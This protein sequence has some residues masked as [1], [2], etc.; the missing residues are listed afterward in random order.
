M[1]NDNDGKRNPCGAYLPLVSPVL[2]DPTNSKCNGGDSQKGF[3]NGGKGQGFCCD[4]MSRID[5]TS[6]WIYSRSYVP[7]VAAFAV[8]GNC[9]GCP[10]QVYEEISY[11]ITNTYG[12]GA[13]PC[14]HTLGFAGGWKN[15][16][17]QCYFGLDNAFGC[18]NPN[19]YGIVLPS[20]PPSVTSHNGS[21][22]GTCTEN[23]MQLT[24]DFFVDYAV[25][26][27]NRA[28]AQYPP[29]NYSRQAYFDCEP[30]GEKNHL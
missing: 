22:N 23:C 11:S 30:P 25:A 17:H 6:Q 8:G 26:G 13:Q 20:T 3:N 18:T 10:N 2:L 7:F 29:T 1:A 9:K 16:W 15:E 24:K 28:M 12:A 19:S 5:S 14:R 27:T 4:M 21:P